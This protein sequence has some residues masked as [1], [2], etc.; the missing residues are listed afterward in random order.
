MIKFLSLLFFALSLNG[1]SQQVFTTPSGTKYHLATCRMARNVS[2]SSSVEKA[3]SKGF[4][5]CKICKPPTSTKLSKGTS[6]KKAKGV[7]GLSQCKGKTKKGIRCKR[8][9]RIGNDYCFQ[10]IP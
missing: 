3:V 10:H 7:N 8:K 9:T 2:Y 6:P 1:Y 5:P 4:M